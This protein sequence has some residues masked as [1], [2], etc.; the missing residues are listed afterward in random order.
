MKPGFGDI[1]S[2]GPRS[3][4]YTPTSWSTGGAPLP[5][6]SYDLPV[7]SRRECLK[8]SGVVARRGSTHNGRIVKPCKSGMKM[9][10]KKMRNK[11]I[12][13][14]MGGLSAEREVSLKVELPCLRPCWAGL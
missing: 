6:I 14:L 8:A 4:R 10:N 5:Q 13:V 9:T 1:K 7:R 3:P 12:G 2:A 11:K